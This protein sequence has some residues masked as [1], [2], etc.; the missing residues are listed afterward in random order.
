MAS[1]AKGSKGKYDCHKNA[2]GIVWFYNTHN[3]PPLP[4]PFHHYLHISHIFS[5]ITVIIKATGTL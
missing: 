2:G 3:I 1:K 4:P 5:K